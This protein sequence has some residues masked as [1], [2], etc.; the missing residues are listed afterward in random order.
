MDKCVCVPF[1]CYF[2]PVRRQRKVI[3]RC[4]W[5]H[6]TQPYPHMPLGVG[7]F[8]LVDRISMDIP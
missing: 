8:F 6:V 3:N 2:L 1:G 5:F 7:G 4:L